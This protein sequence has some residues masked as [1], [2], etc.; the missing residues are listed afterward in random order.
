M[1]SGRLSCSADRPDGRR[2][3]DIR[4]R[5]HMAQRQA[6][7]VRES[8]R[9]CIG[10]VA[11][12]HLRTAVTQHR[13]TNWQRVAPR[14]CQARPGQAMSAPR[15]DQAQSGANR[16]ARQWR[17]RQRHRG[18]AYIISTRKSSRPRP[19]ALLL[20]AAMLVPMLTATYLLNGSA[21]A[22][23]RSAAARTNYSAG[24]PQV[25]FVAP[26]GHGTDRSR[27]CAGG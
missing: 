16:A 26:A 7:Q 27:R 22:V 12:L 17:Q 4:P 21:S 25:R 20:T 2:A 8:A 9:C 6:W 23:E 5:E 13:L 3:G 10:E 11:R 18:N 19:A 14:A 24:W 15:P 1:S